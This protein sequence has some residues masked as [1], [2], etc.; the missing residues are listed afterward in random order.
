[1]R[2]KWKKLQKNENDKKKKVTNRKENEMK[3]EEN[4]KKGK[5]MRYKKKKC[6]RS[7]DST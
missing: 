1:M 7:R 6:P 2:H 5:K 4:D 3:I